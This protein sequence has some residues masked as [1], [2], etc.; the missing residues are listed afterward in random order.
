MN[1]KKAT[2]CLLPEGRSRDSADQPHWAGRVLRTRCGCPT[3]ISSKAAAG[4]MYRGPIGVNVKSEQ[5]RLALSAKALKGVSKQAQR[6]PGKFCC[7]LVIERIL[8]RR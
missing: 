1:A 8:G 2:G 6:K 5:V 4:S 7:L 3:V